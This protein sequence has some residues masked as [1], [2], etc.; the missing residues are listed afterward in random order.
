M[1]SPTRLPPQAPSESADQPSS[2]FSAPGGRLTSSVARLRNEFAG[3][4]PVA[5]GQLVRALLDSHGYYV[6]QPIADRIRPD[7]LLASLGSVRIVAEHLA[8]A[9]S[10]WDEKR[11]PVLRGRFVILGLA[12]EEA[13]G[14]HLLENGIIG[15]LLTNWQPG[16]GTTVE[17][18]A[19]AWDVLS[20]GGRSTIEKQPLL[21]A[22]YGAPAQATTV[23]PAPVQ[24]MAWSGG[25]DRLAVLAGGTVYEFR[26]ER[27][28]PPSGSRVSRPIG[29]FVK[30]VGSIGWD[31]ANGVVGL[32][33]DN[34]H[35]EL[36]RASDGTVVNEQDGIIS[37]LLSG[38][39]LRAWLEASGGVFR[40]TTTESLPVT[41]TAPV[42]PLPATPVAV[43]WTGGQG[44]LSV[45][46]GGLLLAGSPPGSPV[47]GTPP[48]SSAADVVPVLAPEPFGSWPCAL[49]KLGTQTAVTY[50]V[51]DG[52]EVRDVHGNLVCRIATGSGT[53]HALAV[54]PAGTSLA[55]GTGK[56]VRVWPLG[57]HPAPPVVPA[58]AADRPGQSG[59]LLDAGR[60]ARAIASLI[61]ARDVDPPLSIGLFGAWGSGKSFILQEIIG[62]LKTAERSEGYLQ[63]IK[64]VEFNAWQYAETNLWASLVDRVLREIA[65]FPV[66]APPSPPEVSQAE[67][68]AAKASRA[69]VEAG[70]EV[71]EAT[72]ALEQARE[73]LVRQRHH[74]AWLGATVLVLAAVAIIGTLFGGTGRTLTAASAALAL[75]S[76]AAGLLDRSR[77]AATQVEDLAKDGRSGVAWA[78][79]LLG[80]P[81]EL[82]VQTKAA[83]L[84]QLEAK[85]D[86]ANANSERLHHALN[87]VK[88]AA[89]Q[90]PL[91]AL[92]H[93]LATISEYRDQLSLVTRTRDAFKEV[94]DA[95]NTARLG[96][97]QP[98]RPD[99]ATDAD[100]LG[101]AGNPSA[102]PHLDRIV[103]VIDDLDRCPPEKVVKVLEAVHLLF[104]FRMFV[105]LIAVDTRWLEQSLRIHYGQLLGGSTAPAPTDYLE[106]IIQ[107]PLHLLPLDQ[108][109]VRA[110][111]S[112][113]TR[114]AQQPAESE[115]RPEQRGIGRPEQAQS[116]AMDA[117]APGR[118]PLIATVPRARPVPV[119]LINVT[120]PEAAAMSDVALLIG[121]TPRTIKRFVNIYR[122]LKAKS[123]TWDVD[124]PDT[125]SGA[126]LRGHEVAAFLLA[127]VTGRPTA[128]GMVFSALLAAPAGA[129][130][131]QALI[132]L[133]S[134]EPADPI[135]AAEPAVPLSQR[136]PVSADLQWSAEAAAGIA[137]ICAWLTVHR[138]YAEAPAELYASWAREVSRFSFTPPLGPPE[139]AL[140]PQQFDSR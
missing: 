93:R 97:D 112:G 138:P 37:G 54:D 140:S 66:L 64:V 65:E 130:A 90:Q 22:S 109:M 106:K 132:G 68:E 32:R 46:N 13:V 9:R 102:G 31:G 75:I 50:A 3:Q 1:A 119:E 38:D 40:W 51:L 96:R 137:A 19:V 18:Y 89:G 114:S 67:E 94:D 131:E 99:A 108:S 87:Q 123:A 110:M 16:S 107:V 42:Q 113:L 83:V 81:E 33:I 26:P 44:L 29:D 128:A 79:R 63:H 120:G 115:A 53:A 105:V 27:Y 6:D 62:I 121:T 7:G 55:V 78:A 58:Y 122:L 17:P 25:G 77:T 52:V 41:L 30:T 76:A 69:A 24:A 28:E 82:A 73:K 72:A 124:E 8:T 85:R 129:T 127:V 39:G 91:G 10:C 2:R 134:P 60:D 139:M 95:I 49:V 70:K 92:L 74:A 61:S 98:A 111:I 48:G 12:L 104:S 47:P 80:R 100:H 35:A 45:P 20:D 117:G 136:S 84:Q 56:V 71:E 118:R 126:G 133:M 101:S 14:W 116:E 43:D 125:R 4:G 34:G 88:E 11:V 59:D 23:I 135:A 15:S 21:A 103:I 57:A 5:A 36:L 86:A